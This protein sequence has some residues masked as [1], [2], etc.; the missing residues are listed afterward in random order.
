MT[1][2][3]ASSRGSRDARRA[4]AREFGLFTASTIVYQAARFLFSLA[5]ARSLVLE[6]FTAW[7]LVI[8]LLVY[9]PSVLLGITNGMSRELPILIGRGNGEAAD[10]TVAAAWAATLAAVTTILVG[11]VVVAAG[12]LSVASP[13]L[14]F[15]ILAS[16]TIVFGTQQFILRSRLRFD[17]ASAQQATFGGLAL[18]TAAFLATRGDANFAT[19]AVL[20]GAPMMAAVL[21]GVVL[22]PPPN[23]PRL[24]LVEMRRL[25][26][27]GFPIMLAGLVFSLFVTLDRWMA[28][29]LLGPERAAP[30]A[31]ASLVAAAMLVIPTV[32]SQQTYPRMAIAR[33]SGAPAA[34]LRAMARH[35]GLV[36]VG[37]VAPV[38]I[39]IVLFAWL[40]LPV[41]LPRY[42]AATPP[43]VV[44]SLGFVVL[45]YLTGY[46]N[47]LNVAGGQWR[48][49]TAQ[50]VGVACA[51]GLMFV[52][53]R[54]FGLLGIAIGMAV[55]HVIYGVVLRVQALRTELVSGDPVARIGERG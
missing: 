10:R 2:G 18:V 9:A 52:G 44:L 32:V 50:L 33:G 41:V 29:T 7:A 22:A 16:G 36:A 38:A 3:A 49:L 48:Y 1:V 11:S 19:A 13:T 54:F 15:G 43:I 23:A 47:Y 45:G 42:V 21:L 27:I 55:S 20:Y 6:D 5:A 46:G 51:I 37:L 8:A 26:G 30:Y 53:G 39:V 4:R 34:E 28:I 31:L 14:L 40:G 25:A 35:Q 17:A 12:G 24:D